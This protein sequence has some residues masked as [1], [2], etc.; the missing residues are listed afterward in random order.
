M[1]FTYSSTSSPPA[2]SALADRTGAEIRTTGSFIVSKA[3]GRNGY[4]PMNQSRI[5]STCRIINMLNHHSIPCMPYTQSHLILNAMA[6]PATFADSSDEVSSKISRRDFVVS[7]EHCAPRDTARPSPR[8]TAA[9][10]SRR[11]LRKMLMWTGENA[12]AVA[13][14]AIAA[15]TPL[16]I[17]LATHKR[18][19]CMF[20]LW[21]EIDENV[22]RAFGWCPLWSL[23]FRG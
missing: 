21:H 23:Y 22:K 4:A 11:E 16:L 14:Q 17:M 19:P 6:I 13:R 7:R 15:A 2:S 1:S 20:R 8:C 3:Q 18:L 10:C 5:C 12:V 9:V